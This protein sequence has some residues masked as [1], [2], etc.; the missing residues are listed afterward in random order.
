MSV[1]RGV[2]SGTRQVYKRGGRGASA[3]PPSESF[4]S[5]RIATLTLVLPI[6]NVQVGLGIPVLFRQSEIDDVDL[7]PTLADAHQKV[8]GLD[9]PV[10]KVARVNV[11]YA[12][13]LYVR[14]RGWSA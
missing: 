1:D 4:T 3:N 5:N 7:V 9:I 2:T 8:V 14:K 12:G 11:L 6:R 10:D 13:D